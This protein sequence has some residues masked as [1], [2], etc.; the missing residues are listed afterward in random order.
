MCRYPGVIDYA[1]LVEISA[2]MVGNVYMFCSRL[3]DSTDDMCKC[4]FIIAEDRERLGFVIFIISI[5]FDI[6][7]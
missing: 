7:V 1:L 6:F 4:A 2:G 5:V 3:D